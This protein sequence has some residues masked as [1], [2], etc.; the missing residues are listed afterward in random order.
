MRAFLLLILFIP[1]SCFANSSDKT[2]SLL[3][4]LKTEL[5][6]SD[7]YLSKKELHIKKLKESESKINKDD[8]QAQFTLANWLYDEYKSYQFDSAYV[9]VN[10]MI[11]ISKRIN[12]KPKEYYSEV[13]L[14]FILL[15]SGLF[16]ETFRVL[17][18]VDVNKLEDS[19][20]SEYYFLMGR[21]YYDL[22]YYNH[23]KYFTPSYIKTG[24][25][26]L[27]SA[28]YF[29]VDNATAKTYYIGLQK[30]QEGEFEQGAYAFQ[31]LLRQGSLI[32]MHLRA[33]VACS[34]GEI[35]IKSDQQQDGLN[36]TIESAIADVRSSTRETVALYTLAGL[37]YKQGSIE[38]AYQ[39]IKLAK[40]DADFYGARQRKIQIGSILPLIAAE[41]INNSEHQK[42]KILIY[43]LIITSLAIL[44]VIFLVLMFNQLNKVK[45]KEKIIE[46]K[47]VQLEYINDKLLED[48]NIKEE[49][50]GQ[51]FKEIS[52]YILK[53]EKLKMT[54]GTKLSMKKYEDINEL[55]N[56]I[57]IK[58][59]RAS[60]YYSFD[61]IFIK[62]FP[63]F[64]F[65][66][67]SLFEKKDQSWPHENELLN[68]DL[69]IYALIRI[70]IN[71]DDT[72]AK[73]LEY[74]VN[75]IYVY[76]MR[77]KARAID[78]ENFDKQIMAIKAFD[79]DK[80]T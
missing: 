24:N 13:K 41:E 10:K 52:G 76:K 58:N 42:N 23:D 21:S 64:I 53:L 8:Y 50:I 16:N 66:F 2:D 65:A 29:S 1:V 30:L 67:N 48:A 75:T 63:N 49:Y 37:L 9:Y 6:K 59:E 20:K 55:I 31:K 47:N 35:Y 28:I 12:Y 4:V 7:E 22:A 77:I 71:D 34:L 27:D 11:N 51:F 57:D 72:I 80:Q 78:H 26:Y 3:K 69:R 25:R 73:I 74:S 68:T 5:G 43:L 36:M 14:S 17:G 70:G 18:K 45:T 44:V 19:V 60:L 54:V 56:K 40:A 39:F 61:H 33:M 38:D 32:S 62:I 46:D 15:S 79:F